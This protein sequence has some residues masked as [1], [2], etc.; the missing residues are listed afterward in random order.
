[1]SAEILRCAQNDMTLRLSKFHLIRQLR[2]HLP[3]KGKARRNVYFKGR[4]IDMRSIFNNNGQTVI[5]QLS[6]DAKPDHA[7]NGTLLVEMDTGKLYV[8]DEENKQ[9]HEFG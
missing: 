4:E 5:Y 8:Y 3:L 1:M 6:T 7:A 2:C 9:W